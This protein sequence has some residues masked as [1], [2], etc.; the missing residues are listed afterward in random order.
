M[1]V[2]RRTLLAVNGLMAL[3]GLIGVS[4]SIAILVQQGSW[5]PQP[6]AL[7]DTR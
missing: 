1:P 5:L 6:G 7:Q 3:V 2:A 4:Y